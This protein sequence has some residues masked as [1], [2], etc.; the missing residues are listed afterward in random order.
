MSHIWLSPVTHMNE[1]RHTYEWVMSHIWMNHGH[2]SWNPCLHQRCQ[3]EP[4]RVWM[5]HAPRMTESCHTYEWVMATKVE[6][7]VSISAVRIS[8]DTWMRHVTHMNESCHTY[9]WVMAT[10]VETHIL[11]SAMATHTQIHYMYKHVYIYAYHTRGGGLGSSTI[12]NLMSPTPRRKW[13]LTTGRRA[14]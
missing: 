10:Q 13:Y 9:E 2:Q 7:R 11:T 12:S 1:S 8:N 4:C 3:N 5:S 6:I 14:H